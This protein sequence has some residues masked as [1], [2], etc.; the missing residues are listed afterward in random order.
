MPRVGYRINPSYGDDL[1]TE[2]DVVAGWTL[3]PAAQLEIGVSHYS[4]GRYIKESLA[5]V[6]SKDASYLYTQ[7]TLNL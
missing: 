4:R 6:G 5:A 2:V 3:L 7:L 1:G